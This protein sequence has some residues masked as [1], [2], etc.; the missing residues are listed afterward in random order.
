MLLLPYHTRFSA[1]TLPWVTLAL[2]LACIVVWFGPQARDQAR[3]QRAFEYY[4]ESGLAAVELDRYREYLISRSDPDSARRLRQLERVPALSAPAAQLLQGDPRFLYELRAGQIVQPSDRGYPAWRDKR[5]RFDEMLAA[6]VIGRFALTRDAAGEFWRFVTHQFL[7]GS[8]G[9]LLGNMIVLALAGPF[10]EAAL[11]RWRFLIGYLAGG[12]FAGGVH[13]ALSAMPLIGA[14]GAIAAAMAMVA[15]LYGTRRVPV[16]YWIT[17]LFGTARIPA[18][19]LLPAWLV[20]E[21]YQW[22]SNPDSPV[23]TAAHVGGFAAGAAIAWLLRTPDRER[24]N[25]LLEVQTSEQRTPE[26]ESTLISQARDAASRLDTRRASR[27]YRELVE[28]EPQRIEHLSS[29]LNVALLGSDETTLQDAALRLLWLKSRKPSDE[30]RKA[31]LQLTQ[32]K[33]LTALPI[34]EHL[35]LARRLVKVHEDAAALRVLDA[36]LRDDNLR[37]LY[38]RQLADCL[39]GLYTAYV[40]HGLTRPAQSIHSRLSSYFESPDRIGGLAPSTRPPST[41]LT[42]VRTTAGPPGPTPSGAPAPRSKL[43]TDTE[44]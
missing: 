1:Q 18:L 13:L 5:R 16:F 24:V 10:A 26:R 11:G 20:N 33:V 9:H 31:Y 3:E 32:P 23:A 42:G 22:A 19:A 44:R 21:F 37:Q 7:H 36:I 25:R 35:R 17:F 43:P 12:A 6:T 4:F 2:M 34:D 27:L 39:L 38:G 15:V 14:S 30:L 28:L 8:P 41:L 29:Y 40:R